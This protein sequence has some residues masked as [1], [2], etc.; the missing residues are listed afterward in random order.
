MPG[1]ELSQQRLAREIQRYTSVKPQFILWGNVNDVYPLQ[2][3]DTI[4]P[5]QLRSYLN[6]V[7]KQEDYKLIL[8]YQ[9][10]GGFEIL[11]G[12]EE[13]YQKITG[14]TIQESRDLSL[15]HSCENIE[16]L[17]LQ[18]EMP[19]AII[20]SYASRLA[21]T[22]TPQELNEF[23]YRTWRS[24]LNS[25]PNLFSDSR[26]RISRYNLLFWILDKENDLPPWYSLNC[27]HAHT[28]LL[29]KPDHAMRSHIIDSCARTMS[30]FETMPAEKQEEKKS[31]FLDQTGGM[32]ATEIVAIS[33]LARKERI[34]FAQI[35]EAIRRYQTGVTENPWAKVSR[36]TY[37]NAYGFL[38]SRVIGQDI[39]IS[40]SVDVLKR[41]RY[42]LSGSQFSRFSQKPKGVLFLAGPT[43][44]GKTELAKS[45]T[46][47]IFGAP[48]NYLRFDMSEYSHEHADQRLL[49]SPP[50]YVGY[51]VGGQLTNAIREKPFSLVLFDEIEKG[52]PKILDIFLQILDDGRLTS[53]RGE[54]AWFSESL[55]VFTSNLGMFERDAEG[56][57]KQLVT[58]QMEYA[59]IRKKIL[60]SIHKYFKYEISRPEILNRIGNNIVVFDFI[61]PE[62]GLKIFDKMLKS[63]LGT[64]FDSYKIDL[65]ISGKSY[66]KLR[67]LCC[68]DLEMGGRGIGN[69]LEEYFINPL[70]RAL[71]DLSAETGTFEVEDVNDHGDL[72]D[73]DIRQ[74]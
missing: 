16:K 56:G 11:T 65:K 34:P 40:H 64:L 61:R 39:A 47:M 31:I 57:D 50:G 14:K 63:T 1:T 74:I 36:S 24:M 62:A 51:E 18:K 67:D 46:E 37:E 69:A 22:S 10:L 55:I 42:N 30:G 73:L 6:E 66:E 43:G 48:S 38:S 72:I 68:K 41:S 32:Y 52:H 8:C 44:V 70:S 25:R 27:S 17:L 59:D 7:L 23:F 4:V 45:L 29:Q 60:S 5:Y 2:V 35:E 53:G 49:G 3:G 20:L 19:T 9:P 58:P 71:F 33:Q 28:I 15:V 26:D 21:E 54:I 13:A 12:T